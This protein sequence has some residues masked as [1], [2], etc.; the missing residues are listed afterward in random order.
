MISQENNHVLIKNLL[1]SCVDEQSRGYE[2]FVQEHSL[3]YIISGEIHLTTNKATNVG[4]SG[5][6]GLARR[7]QLVKSLKVPP[8]GGQFKAIN[9][10]FTQDALRRYSTENNITIQGKYTG[11]PLF[12]LQ[13]DPFIKGFFESLVPYL[14]DPKHLSDKLIKLKTKEAIELLLQHDEQLKN[15]LFDFSEP[16]KIDLEAFM[17]QNYVFNVSS[18]NFARL[19]GRS[20]A[21]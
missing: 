6:I 17:N 12:A 15:F 9:I 2:Q 18:S 8:P 20:L 21:A 10:I 14:D 13:D 3:G 7:N 16:Y 19:T 5:N 1:Y 4:K 11:E